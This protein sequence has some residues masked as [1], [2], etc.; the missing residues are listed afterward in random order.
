MAEQAAVVTDEALARAQDFIEEEEGAANRLAGWRA[1]CLTVLAVGVSLFHL[2][3]AYSIVPTQT[4]RPVHVAMVLVLT[5]L[6]FPIAKRYR[7]RIM[8]W[9]FAFA[10]LSVA[11]VAYM[12]WGGEDFTDRNTSPL[13][14]DIVFGVALVFLVLEAMRR[15]AGWVMPV[16]TTCFIL[17]ALLGAY[18]PSPWTHKGYEVGRLVGHLYMTLEGIFGVAV[19]VASSLIILFTIFGAFLQYSGAGKFYI[20]FSFSAMGGKPTGAGRTVVLASFLLGG[21][22][23]SGVATTVTL[24]SVAWPMLAKAGYERNAAG[25]LLAAGGLGAIISPPVLGA[26]AFLIAEF[27]KISYLDV[28]LMAVIPTLLFYL[29]LF[30][31]VEIDARKYDMGRTVFAQAVPLWQLTKRYWFH[32]LS[33]VS[34]IVFMMWGFSPVLSVFYATLVTLVTSFIRAEC[35]LVPR[36]VF[37]G[38]GPILKKLWSSNLVKALEAGTTGVLG[39]AA[40][41][42][43]AGIIV[44]VVTLTGLGLKFSSIVIDLAGGSLLLT[45]IYTSLVVWIVGLAVPVTASY[46]ICAV[47]AAP[48]LIKLGVPDFAAHMFIF[49][50]AVL[51]EVSPPTALSPFA[52]SAITGGDPYKTTLQCWK[53]TVPAFLVPFMFVL[54]PSGQGLLLMGSTKALAKANWWAIAEVAATA[55]LGVAAL[56]A[57][58]QGWALK[59]TNVIERSMLLVAGFALVYPSLISDVLGIGLVAGALALQYFRARPVAV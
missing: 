30:L 45:A 2:Y 22:S 20:D 29:A 53:Y 25:G 7:H 8:W 11:V 6:L 27:L 38:E 40:T 37:R 35:A 46:I 47:I 51:S 26:A 56:A 36:E 39:V 41:C 24:G 4:L 16:V 12:L 10:L 49:Y 44:G 57:G 1:A 14:W 34:I 31:M 13:R 15:T 18:L 50:Y 55:A 9:D 19:D 28:L 3:A 17:Y 5:F 48:A 32:F 54:D 33:L 43:G 59:R 58:F 42:A 21:P 23:G 52:A